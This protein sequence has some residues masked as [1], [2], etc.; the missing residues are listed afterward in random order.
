[1]EDVIAG[2]CDLLLLHLLP[3][4]L[5]FPLIPQIHPLHLPSHQFRILLQNFHRGLARYRSAAAD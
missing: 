3:P 5:R 2:A 1:M 4:H